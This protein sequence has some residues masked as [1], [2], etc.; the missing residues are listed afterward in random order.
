MARFFAQNPFW[1]KI[2]KWFMASILVALAVRMA[3]GKA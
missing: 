3:K 1:I 2:Q